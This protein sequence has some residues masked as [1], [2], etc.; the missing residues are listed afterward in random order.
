MLYAA[1]KNGA[2]VSFEEIKKML[3]QHLDSR[4]WK[5][6]LLLP[7]D[8]TRFHS[9]SG[10][11]TAFYYDELIKRGASVKVLPA[12]GTHVP[13]KREE[14]I[15]MF[16]AG[17]PEDAYLVHDFRKSV[18]E[19]G[20]VP[21]EVMKK[22][23]QGLFTEDVR[24][25]VNRE[26]VS[27][28]YDAILSIGQVISHEIAGMAGYTK[29]LL[30]G[31][32]GGEMINVSHFLGVFYGLERLLG[33]DHN[34]VRDL[35]DYVQE[36]ILN[37]IMPLT[38]IQTVMLQ[39]N[40]EDTYRGVY[41][42]SDR[43]A[44]ERAVT[45]CRKVNFNNVERP[46][47]KCVVW[48]D[49]E[50]YHSTWVTNKAIY[51]TQLA[52]EQGGEIIIIAPGVRMFGENDLAD[53]IIRKYGYLPRETVLAM[54]KTEPALAE[55]LSM[56]GHLIHG[57]PEGI[58]VTYCTDRLSREEIEH[59]NFS[60]LSVGEALRR[61][62]CEDWKT[63]W[64]IL[65]DGEEIFFVRNAGLG[66]WRCESLQ[67]QQG[68]KSMSEKKKCAVV[69]GGTMGRQIGLNAAIHGYETVVCESVEAV[70]E[71]LVKW[72]NEYLAGRIAKGK[73]TEEQVTEIKASF[74]VTD[75]LAAAVKDAEVVIE[76]IIED[77]EAKTKVL[78]QISELCPPDAVIG[79]NSSFM[80]SSLFK[81]AVKN[82]SRLT[83]THFF[84]PA[85]VMKLVEVV[86]GEHTSDE[87][88]QKAMDYCRAV[89]KTPVLVRKEEDGFI[90]NNVLKVIKEEAYRL[91]NNGVCSMEDLDKA[92]KLGLGHPMG[93]YELDDLNGI[94]VRYNVLKR[95][96]EETGVKSEGFDMIEKLYKEGRYGKKNGHGFYDYV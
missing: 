67:N 76:A 71:N 82:P 49:P 9:G 94:D 91:V 73:M 51:R 77:R 66:M 10:K 59:A 46:I 27:G 34:P 53:G 95:R 13:M 5:R 16:G 26:L 33:E 57:A 75:D 50:S 96:Y 14:Q 38:F 20:T 47:H 69:G 15:R 6:V 28:K 83:N 43:Q 60:Y 87:T 22:I 1:E 84:A 62:P 74:R 65:E 89:G 80:V 52:V 11:I 39:E 18:T 2:E 61:Y 37:P 78:A 45:L 42:S 36:T 79:T 7:P 3:R 72:E 48:M 17:I 41:I 12:L 35:F 44:F 70:R 19:I 86:K 64:H 55:N 56:A 90:V 85:L 23:S 31:C 4:E 93:P 81:D 30:V 68:G 21:A 32:G 29:N 92:V 88:I 63:G 25:S 40:G 58:K 8:I 24:V 54:R